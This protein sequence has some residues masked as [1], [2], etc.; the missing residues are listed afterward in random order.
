MSKRFQIVVSGVILAIMSALIVP[1]LLP[2]P[3]TAASGACRNNLAQIDGATHQWALEC[4]KTTN[5]SPTWED[6]R[7]FLCLP[8]R[9]FPVC[10]RGGKY[11]LG[12][13]NHLPKCSYPGHVL[14]LPRD[15]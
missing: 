7:P 2:K 13:L 12:D 5:D 1:H 8:G 6:L 10:D 15:L 11:I 3:R 9:N 4:G 14:Q